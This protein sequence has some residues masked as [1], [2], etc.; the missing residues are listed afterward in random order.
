MKY[1]KIRKQVLDAILERLNKDLSKEPQG[2]LHFGTMKMML[3]RLLQ[4][5]YLIKE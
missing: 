1:E 3:W 2:I 5:E 4:A